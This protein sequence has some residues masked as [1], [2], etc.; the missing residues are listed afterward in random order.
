[1]PEWYFIVIEKAEPYAINI[2]RADIGFIDHGIILRE[3]LMEKLMSCQEENKYPDYGINDLM[4]P[5]WAA[6]R[7]A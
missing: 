5:Y 3:Q 4:L 7:E 6:E 2:L 1:M